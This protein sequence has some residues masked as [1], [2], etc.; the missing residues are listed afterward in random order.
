MV[1]SSTIAA[2]VPGLTGSADS[3]RYPKC[4]LALETTGS[5]NGTR[6]ISGMPVLGMGFAVDVGA[7]RDCETGSA[8]SED[9]ERAPETK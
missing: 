3:G 8:G 2:R 4:G 7:F 1:P 9:G 5:L 6:A